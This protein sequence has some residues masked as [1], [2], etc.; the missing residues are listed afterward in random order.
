M[1]SFKA[2]SGVIGGAFLVLL[3]T[4]VLNLGS[5]LSLIFYA[6]MF[7][8]IWRFALKWSN[9]LRGV[10]VFFLYSALT[11][12]LFAWQFYTNPEYFGFSGGP[13]V[14]TDDSFFYSLVAPDLPADFP[15]RDGFWLRSHN[16]TNILGVVA[17]ALAFLRLDMH[18]LDLLFFNVLGLSFVPFFAARVAFQATQDARAAAF[19]CTATLICPFLITNSLILIR[20][21]WMALCFIGAL[22]FLMKRRYLM[23]SLTLML[24]VYLRF[25]AGL[26]LLASI[27]LYVGLIKN[28]KT[29]V[30]GEVAATRRSLPRMLV[31]LLL[32]FVALIFCIILIG[33]TTFIN[34]A[35]GLA[36]REGFLETFI[37]AS[38]NTGSGGT[39]YKINQFPWFI[40]IP[41]GF[42]F[43]LGSP[44][45]TL[46]GLI[47]DGEYIPRMVLA[48]LF[49]LM[50]IF[51]F[52]FFIRGVVRV[53]TSS[54]A[55]MGVL[56]IIFLIDVLV[57]SQASM[58]IRHKVALM[59]MFYVIAA[60][61]FVYK[62]SVPW[63][64][65]L[66]ASIGLVFVTLGVNAI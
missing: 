60:Y 59:P 9:L 27:S 14:G 43:F 41:L 21:G 50:F 8:L 36:Y 44:F 56:V 52:A 61:G 4:A 24:A 10:S 63:I 39:F 66:A 37:A 47:S 42:L 58:Q 3:V 23:L 62:R 7:S 12:G 11:M 26:L 19:A 1:T 34:I 2:V 48:N 6:V 31:I 57:L 16:Y 51:Y 38:T 33:P 13:G 15:V 5:V 55:I 46:S 40:S 18:P 54:N 35:A 64:A 29:G 45:F 25:E 32:P 22:Y 17:A 65:G 53:L 30:A 49:S 20:D 28:R